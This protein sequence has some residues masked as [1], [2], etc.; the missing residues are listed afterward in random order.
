MATFPV[1]RDS[2]QLSE[3]QRTSSPDSTYPSHT[4]S[5][6]ERTENKSAAKQQ[7]LDPSIRFS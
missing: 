2:T 7:S 1:G 3:N 6:P 5:S 4:P